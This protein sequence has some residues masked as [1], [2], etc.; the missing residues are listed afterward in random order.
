MSLGS[1]VQLLESFSL[2][3]MR[4]VWSTSMEEMERD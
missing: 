4:V 1:S 2:G 3:L